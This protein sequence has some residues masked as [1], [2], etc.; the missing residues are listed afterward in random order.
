MNPEGVQE[1]LSLL[2]P[3]EGIFAGWAVGDARVAGQA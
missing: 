3:L 1:A 2:A